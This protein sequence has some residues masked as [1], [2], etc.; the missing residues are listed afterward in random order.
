MALRRKQQRLRRFVFTL[1]NWTPEE[2]EYIVVDFAPTTQ[3]MIVAQELGANGTPHL[4]GACVLGFQ[5]AFSNLKTTPGFERAHVEPMHGTPQ[6]SRAYCSKQDPEPFEHGELP[7]QGKRSDLENASEKILNGA[8]LREL[9]HDGNATMIVKYFKGLTTLRSLVR[10]PRNGPPTVFWLHGPTGTGKTR[11][12]MECGRLLSQ[13][14]DDIWVS[15]GTLRWFDGYD[16]QRVAVFDDFRSKHVSSFA[17]LL[18]LLDRYPTNV[19]IKGGFV[20]WT[21]D[22]IFITSSKHPDQT[23]ETRKNFIPEDLAQLHRRLTRIIEFSDVGTCDDQ[24]RDWI[25]GSILALCGMEISE[26]EVASDEDLDA[27]IP[28]IDLTSD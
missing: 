11:T 28:I 17:F 4:Q 20:N 26:E 25:Q 5:M 19:E 3:W 27:T 14:V 24:W 7:K 1:N 12:A 8:T 16:G 22:V 9:A 10:P 2:Y 13:G 15:S 6:D 23:F 18:R 21:P